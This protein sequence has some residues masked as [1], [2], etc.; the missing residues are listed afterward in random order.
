MK[1]QQKNSK[2]QAQKTKRPYR[3]PLT[4]EGMKAI[5]RQKEVTYFDKWKNWTK[6]NFIEEDYQLIDDTLERITPWLDKKIFMKTHNGFRMNLTMFVSEEINGQGLLVTMKCGG[7][8]KVTKALKT[9]FR[10][11][12]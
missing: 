2:K 5:D 9:E 10:K 6:V 12:I 8:V 1:N 7:Q 4:P 3:R 11:R